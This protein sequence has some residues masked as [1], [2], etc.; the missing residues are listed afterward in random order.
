MNPRCMINVILVSVNIFTIV[1]LQITTR[2][3]TLKSLCVKAHSGGI[4]AA[5]L[6]V[7]FTCCADKRGSIECDKI[8]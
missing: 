2:N 5:G 7:I 6:M 3:S 8:S 1:Q 4:Q